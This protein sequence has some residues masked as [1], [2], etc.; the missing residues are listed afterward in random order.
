ML[1]GISLL[2][3]VLFGVCSEMVSVIGNLVLRWFIIGIM[4]DVDSVMWWCDRLYVLLLSIS[5]IVGM[6]VL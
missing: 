4:L 1:S 5:C 2:C 6:I 3:S